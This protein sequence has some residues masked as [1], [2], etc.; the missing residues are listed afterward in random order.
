M[1]KSRNQLIENILQS[2]PHVVVIK[3]LN[4]I[5]SLMWKVKKLKKL[6]EKKTAKISANTYLLIIDVIPNLSVLGF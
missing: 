4:E 5:D 6:K 3:F 1:T 2:I